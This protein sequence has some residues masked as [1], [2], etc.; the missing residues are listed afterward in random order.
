LSRYWE[1]ANDSVQAAAD[2]AYSAVSGAIASIYSSS[3]SYDYY[4]TDASARGRSLS[5]MGEST[6]SMAPGDDMSASAR[7]G[8]GGFG[9]A[10]VRRKSFTLTSTDLVMLLNN[11]Y[12]SVRGRRDHIQSRPASMS[13]VRALLALVPV[14]SV[15]EEESGVDEPG[16]RRGRPP[17]TADDDE[18]L[19]KI[20]DVGGT[21]ARLFVPLTP[22]ISNV[23]PSPAGVPPL[24]GPPGADDD[25]VRDRRAA[26]GP[27]HQQ[28]R[29][30]GLVV[31][32]SETASQ[33][34]EGT[35]RAMRDLLC[36]EAVELQ[37][38]LRFWTERWERPVFSWLEA[39][40]R[41]T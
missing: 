15:D 32:P 36:D 26:R 38:A 9:G 4:Q 13:A 27:P 41:G 21:K 1:Y 11:P 12:S 35:I 22:V 37:V 17:S 6:S 10:P 34:A 40:P 28:Q 33:I 31:S 7:G 2:A 16:V 14:A 18:A 20:R 25:S 5:N 29:R 19:E 3:S 8:G 24:L 39:G 23:S 30:E